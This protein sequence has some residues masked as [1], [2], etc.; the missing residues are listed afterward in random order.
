MLVNTAS[1]TKDWPSS[2]IRVSG[3]VIPGTGHEGLERR[4]DVVLL[5]L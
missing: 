4:R 3:E 2:G 5:F 1:G